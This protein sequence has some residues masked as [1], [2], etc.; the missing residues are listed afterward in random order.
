MLG[1]E[2]RLVSLHIHGRL[3]DLL[4]ARLDRFAPLPREKS[5]VTHYGTAPAGE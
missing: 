2:S 4:A 5:Q 1:L 3:L